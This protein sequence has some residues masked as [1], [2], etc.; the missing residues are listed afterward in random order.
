MTFN[1]PTL[2]VVLELE[3]LR[4]DDVTRATRREANRAAADW[5]RS[6]GLVP[7]GRVWEAM[8][9]GC[10]DILTLRSLSLADGRRPRGCDGMRTVSSLRHGDILSGHG[11]VT[12]D[13]VT[14]PETGHMWVTVT[15]A[16]GA[17]SDLALEPAT[18]CEY[19]RPRHAP[20]WVQAAAAEYRDARDAWEAGR[21]SD[22]I[23][24]TSVPGA[25]GSAVSCAQLEPADYAQA[26]PRPL[27]KDFLAE[28][29]ARLRETA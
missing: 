6:N 17:V 16:D 28:H 8:R 26:F 4:V 14:D 5:C 23:V 29:A 1:R 13:P 11:T 12:G 22:R 19:V 20:A 27:F 15:A 9:A 25:A 7:D 21:E 3:P 24:P 10:R 2:P 18:P